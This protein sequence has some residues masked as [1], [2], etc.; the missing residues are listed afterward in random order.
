MARAYT[1][2]DITFE[3]TVTQR[4]TVT[5]KSIDA[6][7]DEATQQTIARQLAAT[8]LK[9]HWETTETTEPEIVELE[10]IGA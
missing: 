1:H 9:A 3:R 6:A 8:R 4:Q 2:H 10:E 7:L 5:I